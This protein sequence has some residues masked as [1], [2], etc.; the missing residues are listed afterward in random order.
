MGRLGLV[1]RMGLVGLVM[2]SRV[3]GVIDSVK[4][5]LRGRWVVSVGNVVVDFVGSGVMD[6][7]GNGVMVLVGSGVVISV[8]SAMVSR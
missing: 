7:V 2:G 6:S 4:T 3:G 1:G 5:G 8:E